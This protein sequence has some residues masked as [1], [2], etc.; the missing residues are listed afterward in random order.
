MAAAQDTEDAKAV[1]RPF[2][3]PQFTMKDYSSF[4]LAGALC[5]T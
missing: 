3:I 5:A 1:K 2:V 4:F